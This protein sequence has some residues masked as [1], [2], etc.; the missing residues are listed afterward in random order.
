MMEHLISVALSP[1]YTR[2][3]GGAAIGSPEER[4]AILKTKR[5]QAF[6]NDSDRRSLANGGPRSDQEYK[7]NCGLQTRYPVHFSAMI[8][9]VEVIVNLIEKRGEDPNK[10][11][12]EINDVQ[13]IA[14]AASYGQLRAVIALVAVGSTSIATNT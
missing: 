3:S 4:I 8:G 5:I 1:I 12:A 10:K 13:P 9:D 7:F 2:S 14:V 11:C 6:L